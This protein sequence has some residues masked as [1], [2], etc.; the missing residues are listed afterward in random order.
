[1][2]KSNNN[3]I[4][5]PR[6]SNKLGRR[7]VLKTGLGFGAAAALA[8]VLAACSSD[9]ADETSNT[10]SNDTAT[11]PDGTPAEA[12][13][14][15]IKVGYIGDLTGVLAQQ[16]QIQ[17]N[18][19]ELAVKQI[20]ESGGIGGRPIEAVTEDTASDSAQAIE[21]STKLAL[22][23]EVVTV[24]GGITSS[25]RE[26][27]LTVLPNEK[28]P[29]FYTTFYEGAAAGA[30][31]C[32]EYLIATGQIPNQQVAPLVP[33]LSENVGKKYIVVGND[34][35]W[36]RGMTEVLEELLVE[37]GG[38][39]VS[40][41][42]FPL[43]TTDFGPF[44]KELADADAD[45][46]WVTLVGSDQDTFLQQYKQF[47]ATTQIVSLSMN[48]DIAATNPEIS[49]GVITVQN[50]LAGIESGN[51]TK[52]LEEYRAE[53]G[54]DTFPIAIGEGAYNSVYLFKGAVEAADGS[55]DPT[56]WIPKL[57]G[58][59][60]DSPSG[61]IGIDADTQHAITNS[62]IGKVG[63]D[64]VIEILDEEKAVVPVVEGCI[65]S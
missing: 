21:K 61:S 2:S 32:D 37:E 55:T 24:I 3:S 35:I 31:A 11:S 38:E 40:S 7:L 58:V 44:F 12:T 17:L 64:G 20:N 48:D 43:G 57:S 33:Y 22:E 27:A 36:P 30:T 65:L 34:Y 19:F 14:D 41:T 39:V 56:D 47:G 54:A 23:D 51:N 8:P 5:D 6:E 59:S 49:E 46:C 15:P 4:E 60:F 26:A 13:G 28:I 10:G 62:Y 1:M 52:F 50:Y 25:V 42:Y 45:I 16:G 63:A 9:A 29:F 53:N 18:C